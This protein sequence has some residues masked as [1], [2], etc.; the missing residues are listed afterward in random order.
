MTMGHGY[1]QEQAKKA[2]AVLEQKIVGGAF[3]AN[4]VRALARALAASRATNSRLGKDL[5][6]ALTG[7]PLPNPTLAHELAVKTHRYAK[8]GN[9]TGADELAL[10]VLQNC[11]EIVKAVGGEG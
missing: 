2:A 5:R 4:N 6:A 1:L 7:R 11:E 9:A 8:Y 10:F 3:H